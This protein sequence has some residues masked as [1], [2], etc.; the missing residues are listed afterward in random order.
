MICT[1]RLGSRRDAARLAMSRSCFKVAATLAECQTGARGHDITR[2]SRNDAADLEVEIAR[3]VA[4]AKV[5][6]DD[7][8]K[9]P[10]AEREK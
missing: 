8:P 1:D 9:G 5:I 2:R 10:L 6:I 3:A 7:V 4:T